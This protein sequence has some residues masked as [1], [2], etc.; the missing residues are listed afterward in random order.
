[1]Q[2]VFVWK[3]KIIRFPRF[4]LSSLM[5]VHEA[6]EEEDFGEKIERIEGED[7]VM[8]DEDKGERGEWGDS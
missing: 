6:D 7:V 3:A 4:E 8:E 2:N 1:M 5:A